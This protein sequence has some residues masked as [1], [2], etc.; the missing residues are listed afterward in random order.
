MQC[1][2]GINR[3]MISRQRKEEIVSLFERKIKGPGSTQEIRKISKE[4][5]KQTLVGLSY[6]NED[7]NLHQAINDE[8]YQRDAQLQQKWLTVIIV[9]FIIGLGI[10][11][12]K[13]FIPLLP[14]AP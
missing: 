10:F 1:L 8:I 7:G 5:L 14:L 11:L 4:E 12:G 6:R 2:D 3:T 9:M 13:E